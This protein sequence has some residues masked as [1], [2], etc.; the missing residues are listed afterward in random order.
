MA[1][2]GPRRELPLPMGEKVTDG[3]V[4]GQP[5]GNLGRC[6]FIVTIRALYE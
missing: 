4:V 1:G 3:V 6:G 5:L 2:N